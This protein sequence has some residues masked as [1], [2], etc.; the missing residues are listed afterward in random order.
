MAASHPLPKNL[1][2]RLAEFGQRLHRMNAIQAGCRLVI[3]LLAAACAA[4]LL[5]ALL[6]FPG[7]LRGSLLVGW[8]ALGLYEGRRFVRTAFTRTLDA[9]GLAA[10][11]EH[12]YPRL[13]E[14]LTT[15]VE[16]A[17]SNDPANGS[18]ELI[19][20]VIR[21]VDIR[22]A[23]L[24]L[25]RAAPVKATIGFAIACVV[26]MAAVITPLAALPSALDHA[27]RFFIPWHKPVV[28]VTFRIQ[29]TSGDPFIKRGEHTTLSALI[30][31]LKADAV[32]PSSATLVI[33]SSTGSERLPMTFDADKREAYLSRG[34]LE[35]DFDYQIVSGDVASEWRH[36]TVIDPVRIES[37]RITV[38]P[39]PYARVAGQPTPALDGLAEIT[40]LQHS[41]ITFDLRFNR[42]PT[43]VWL[44]WKP[45]NEDAA[46]IV[47][48]YRMALTK[49]SET[50]SF[51]VPAR[52]S[53]DLRLFAEIDKVKTA[54]R[55][56]PL[57]VSIDYPPQFEEIT[58]F[59]AQTR[60]VRPGEKLRVVCGVKD[61]VA[62]S[63][64]ELEWRVGN[65]SP[66]RIELPLKG[67]ATPKVTARYDLDLATIAKVDDVVSYRL[68]ATDNR[69]YPEKKLLP[70]QTFYPEN[71]KWAELR[72]KTEAPPLK[73][74]E[75]EKKKEEIDE[76]VRN[77]VVAL[78]KERTAIGKLK[79][80]AAPQ[81]RMT[82]EQ[83]SR[84]GQSR[85]SVQQIQNSLED[86]GNDIARTPD[87]NRLAQT[88]RDVAQ[89]DLREA[90]DA[91]RQAYRND[92]Q[93][94]RQQGLTRAEVALIDAIRKLDESYQDNE[95]LAKD[96]LEIQKFENVAD[97][98]M[99]LAD[100]TAEAKDDKL[101]VLEK[102]QQE[103]ADML[104][105]LQNDS[106]P[107]RQAIRDLQ[108]RQQQKLSRETQDLEQQLR[109]LTQ[110]M[111][112]TEQKTREGRFAGLLRKQ[113]DLARRAQDLAERSGSAARAAPLSPLKPEE[114]T[115]AIESL[116][117]GNLNDAVDQQEKAAFE[118]DRLAKDLEQAVARSK[119]PREAA[120][121]L[122]RLQEDLRQKLAEATKNTPY[123][124]L[125]PERKAALAKQEK[126]IQQATARLS[127]PADDAA[128]EATRQIAIEQAAKTQE[129]LDRADANTADEQMQKTRDALRRLA[130][131]LPTREKRWAQARGDLAKIRSEQDLL[132]KKIEPA[133]KLFEKRDNNDPAVAQ[134][135]ARQNADVLKR[136]E[137]ALERLGK[138]DTPGLEERK[139]K[140]EAALRQAKIDLEEGKALDAAGSQQ[141]ARRELERLEQALNGQTPADEQA[142]RLAKKQ[143][144]IADALAKNAL[145]PDAKRTRE[146]QQEQ[147]Q[148]TNDLQK[149][150]APEVPATKDDALEL[151]R[152]TENAKTPEEAAAQ[153]E[154]A[155]GALQRLADQLNGREPEA[156]RVDRLAK[157]Q[158]EAADDA[159]RLA[160]KKEISPELRRKTQQLQDE[161]KNLRPGAAGQR[162]RQQA[163]EALERAQK[164]MQPEQ[165]ARA[166]RD[167]AE[168]LQRLADQLK[169]MGMVEPALVKKDREPLSEGL[170][171]Q[172]LADEARQLA[173]EQRKLRDELARANEMKDKEPKK[174]EGNPLTGLIEEQDKITRESS[175]LAKAIGKEKDAEAQNARMASEAAKQAAAQMRNGQVTPAREAGAK[176]TQKL[177]QL[178]QGNA[179]DAERKQAM[180]LA[181][182]QEELNKK[183]DELA[184]NDTAAQAQQAERQKDLQEQIEGLTKQMRKFAEAKSKGG[185]GEGAAASAMHA[186][187]AIKQA[188]EQS[189]K[190][191]AE[192]ARMSQEKAADALKD[193]SRQLQEGMSKQPGMGEGN[194]AGQSVQDARDQ[195][196]RALKDLARGKP[197]DA[198][199]SMKNANESLRQATER[200]RKPGQGS[201]PGEPKSGSSESGVND[202]SATDP[203]SKQALE[204]LA[205]FKGKAWG[206]L[207][208]EI[209]NQI[210]SDM[211]TRYGEE[212]ASYIKFYF[213]HLA[214]R[215]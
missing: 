122:E 155:A 192:M 194:P 142:D 31:S 69:D 159:D 198:Q 92:R 70:Q 151:N 34:P 9:E 113:E 62:V 13:G 190:N 76:R 6:H 132:A 129:S 126:A 158:K 47:P 29:V 121:Q 58:G 97:Q 214:E 83:I 16:I 141:A 14:R 84:L 35:G 115:K 99:D 135:F 202:G 128:A 80:E 108:Q 26:V 145:K 136:E 175:D 43:A 150:P 77:L 63:K 211:K 215:K 189:A 44:E 41:T 147:S 160:K 53:G 105:K 11:I 32:L 140:A 164:S 170:P 17:G 85:Q 71:E 212:Y 103:L 48:A 163:A 98:Q 207:P 179:G 96:R 208:G 101:A 95:R 123:D 55:E 51:T 125:P 120:R 30:E 42:V 19:N 66:R 102:K 60:D 118:L 169:P 178:G 203:A 2:G 25:N 124:Q 68:I 153:A 79:S 112:Q 201:T 199:Q 165:V 174:G 10:A 195:M 37:A 197:K 100:E 61:D 213:E 187:E 168:S 106:E 39:P 72:L 78:K 91:L 1:R 186:E 67:Q 88:F 210:L 137:Q 20:I 156:E 180:A 27:Q 38:L 176:S 193:A 172:G 148:L 40:A 56:Q 73:K 28:E 116:R 86:L 104:A 8:L 133:A 182:R 166:Q 110:A 131:Q 52:A 114:I 177:Q 107:L 143:R 74:Q 152:K 54:F 90:D 144:E 188:R 45:E 12:E 154:Q 82:E 206:D 130:E 22:T 59:T 157:K 117:G 23:K 49:L 134:E 5:D 127:V 111:R 15:A 146:L 138:L 87:L 75:I 109:D 24:D 162:D 171:N 94:T 3:V 149:L 209:K 204:A 200:M 173:E 57:R 7:W 191:Q 196:E 205:P 89:S 18:P 185:K 183:L 4:V 36:V 167:A 184:N 81:L 21:D 161:L 64:V 65:G 139:A 46:R 33:R 119:D 93:D 181:R 50:A